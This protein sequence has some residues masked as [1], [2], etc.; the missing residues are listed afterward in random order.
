[1]KVNPALLLL[2][3]FNLLC[4]LA[5]SAQAA[6]AGG[7]PV[8][9]P[10]SDKPTLVSPGPEEEP[11]E[12]LLPR[13][14]LVRMEVF[15]LSR[16]DARTATRKFPKQADL[17]A[18]LGAELEKEKPK[19]KLERLMILRVR[20][21]QRSKVQEID[22]Y[23]F[24]TQFD[25]PQIPQSIGIGQPAPA[26]TTVT[27]TTPT[28]PPGPPAPAS[29]SAPAGAKGGLGPS[30]TPAAA[31]PRPAG[32]S[33]SDSVFSPWPYTTTTPHSFQ[34]KDTGWTV[35][36]ELTM[37]DDG[38]TVDLNIAPEFIRLCG[39]ENQSP[40]GEVVQPVFETS[41]IAT[42]IMTKLGQPTLAG[43][44]SPPVDAGASGGNLETVTRLLFL[45]VTEPR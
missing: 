10:S 23:P 26:T 40:S 30:G 11:G 19:V 2:A 8:P 36:I 29:P 21:G 44:F 31:L 3:G 45:T 17:Y 41:R 13:E 24:P 43:T 14:G 33:P 16:E 35:E 37:S 15:T 34:I 18:W 27:V 25:P 42:Q 9:P 7:E 1:M 12:N 38:E 22:E 28:P 32:S 39:L 20:G 5:A 4:P 6:S